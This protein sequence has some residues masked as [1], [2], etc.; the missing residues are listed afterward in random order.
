[1]GTHHYFVIPDSNDNVIA[2]FIQY[3]LD[4]PFPE[5]LATNGYSCTIHSCPLYASPCTTHT[6][7]YFPHDKLIFCKHL[8]YTPAVD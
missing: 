1:M 4:S 7:S 6:A 8:V 5:L 3:D 2:P